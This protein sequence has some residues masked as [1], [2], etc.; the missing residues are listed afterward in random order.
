MDKVNGMAVYLF[1]KRRKIAQQFKGV[2]KSKCQG[3]KM[4]KSEQNC[5]TFRGYSIRNSN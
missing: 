4:I 5:P 1:V 3:L 2:K